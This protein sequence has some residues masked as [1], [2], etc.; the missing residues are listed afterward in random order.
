MANKKTRSNLIL[1]L[2]VVSVLGALLFAAGQAPVEAAAL[3]DSG[4]CG[5]NLTWTLDDEGTLTISGTGPMD[6]DSLNQ[7]PWMSYAETVQSV[8]I[9]DG[10]TSIGNNAFVDCTSLNGVLIADS[11]TSIGEGAFRR[12]TS[13]SEITIP[14]GVAQISPYAFAGCTSLKA[15]SADA[16]NNIYSSSSGLLY[17]KN[18]TQLIRC[19]I[20][21]TGTLSIPVTV[22]EIADRAFSECEGISELIILG[23]LT[24]VGMNTF[25]GC[26]GVKTVTVKG[27]ISAVNGFG[28]EGFSGASTFVF[29]GDAPKLTDFSFSCVTASIYYPAGNDT[30]TN[31]VRDNYDWDITWVPVLERVTGLKAVPAG[32]DRVKLSWSKTPG[33]T[34]YAVY[35]Y[36][37]STKKYDRIQ[38]VTTNTYTDTGLTLGASYTYAVKAYTRANGKNVY[39]PTSAKASGRAELVQVT[40]L[41]AASAG[42]DCI[43]L[44]WSKVPGAAKY[45]VYRYNAST[46][47]YD[48]I[49]NVTTNTYTDTGLTVGKSYTYVIRAYAPVNGKNVYGPTS[50]K[51]VLKTG[52][53]QVTGV[54]AAYAGNSNIKISWKKVPGATRYAVYRYNA[55]TKKYDRIKNVTANSYTDTGLS[56]GKSYTYAIRAY[57]PVNGKNVYG[58]T[59]AKASAKIALAQVVGVKAASAGATSIKVTWNKVPNATK[60]ALYRYNSTTGKYD[61]IK[62]VTTNYHTDTGLQ[63]NETYTYAVKAYTAVDGKNM[64]GATSAKASAKTVLPKVT[65]LKAASAGADRI[66]LTWSKV[67]GATRYAVYRYNPDTQKYDRIKNVKTNTY[68]DIDLTFGESYTYVIK[69]YTPVNGKNV[70]SASSAKVTFTATLNPPKGV[71]AASTVKGQVKLTWN[72]VAGAEGYIVYWYDYYY[73]DFY[74]IAVL[75]AD[76]RSYV[77]TEASS[78]YVEYYIIVAWDEIPGYEVVSFSE[79]CSVNVK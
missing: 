21:L 66:K 39:G 52:L 23:D 58:P 40:G 56:I 22:T 9:E 48:R 54:K 45:A 57:A 30:W 61:R 51:A 34:K 25:S 32:T 12:C 44:S 4:T 31:I 49:K 47:K 42:A 65:G 74:P 67:A 24:R 38:N 1:L 19:P 18:K 8:I 71:K 37:T 11:V 2:A 41:K 50:A 20:G 78:G 43:K 17:N 10:V 36:N 26:N 70:Y 29:E 64:Y 46:K 72:Q 27:N 77:D 75:D 53:I 59:S 6:D 7:S 5:Q 28:F 15:I 79:A 60:Y 33:A 16:E 73:E 68:T 63:L 55:S 62:N 69:A 13:L 35:R 3:V 14:K 76:T